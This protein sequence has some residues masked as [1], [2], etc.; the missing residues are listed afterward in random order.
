MRWQGDWVVL[1]NDH[2]GRRA[3]EPNGAAHVCVADRGKAAS[4]S[5]G[6]HREHVLPKWRHDV[7]LL[8]HV[9]WKPVGEEALSNLAHVGGGRYV[10]DLL[11]P[12]LGRS[13]ER[14]GVGQDQP[15]D[16]IRS[17][18]PQPLV[19]GATIMPAY[20]SRSPRRHPNAYA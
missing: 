9:R 12:L 3:D 2:D 4:Q 7:I 11:V 19:V 6:A 1:S 17:V 5:L 10:V 20:S 13:Q 15:V 8:Q 14:R 16:S 18:N